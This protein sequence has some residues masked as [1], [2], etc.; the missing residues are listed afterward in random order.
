[1]IFGVKKFRGYIAYTHFTI[2]T[3]HQALKWFKMIKEPAGR[4][5]RWAL[6]L[7]SFD[8]ESLSEG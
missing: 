4:L 6:E 8:Y 2:Q 1:M 7:Q 5:A 3:D